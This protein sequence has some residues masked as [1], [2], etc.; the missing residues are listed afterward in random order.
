LDR[1]SELTSSVQTLSDELREAQKILNQG[2]PAT[3]AEQSRIADL[4]AELDAAR[5]T[6]GELTATLQSHGEELRTAREDQDRDRSTAHLDQVRLAEATA[7]LDT[8]RDKVTALTTSL[9]SRTE[10]LRALD[11]SRAEVVTELER[12]RAR[13]RELETSLEELRRIRDEERAEWANEAQHLR[14]LLERPFEAPEPA[15]VSEPMEQPRSPAR[16]ETKNADHNGNPVVASVLE[17][18][19]KLR[20]QRALDRSG[21]KKTR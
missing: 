8:A 4:T 10:E 13:Q 3:E 17:Q 21:F 6:I 14:G 9:L 1:N 20:Q 11:N 2:Q 12:T 7:E 15:M 16:V 5:A 18:F 19:G